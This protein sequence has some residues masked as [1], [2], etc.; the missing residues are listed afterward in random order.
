VS[1]IAV[2]ASQATSSQ[3]SVSTWSIANGIP[4]NLNLLIIETVVHIGHNI[5]SAPFGSCNNHS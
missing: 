3:G 5:D 1:V 4:N 2:T